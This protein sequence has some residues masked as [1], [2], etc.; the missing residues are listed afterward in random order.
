MVIIL[1][2]LINYTTLPLGTLN[3]AQSQTQCEGDHNVISS[4]IISIFA[5]VNILS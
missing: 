2:F 1:Y 5:K 4:T 3:M